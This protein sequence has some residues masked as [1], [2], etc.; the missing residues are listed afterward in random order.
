ME[1]DEN[2]IPFSYWSIRRSP[3]PSSVIELPRYA[4]SRPSSSSTQMTYTTSLSRS[5]FVKPGISFRSAIVNFLRPSVALVSSL[6]DLERYFIASLILIW[7]PLSSASLP[8][9]LT[10]NIERASLSVPHACCIQTSIVWSRLSKHWKRKAWCLATGRPYRARSSCSLIGCPASMILNDFGSWM[11]TFRSW[12]VDGLVLRCS[13]CNSR[14]FSPLPPVLFFSIFF[15]ST[16]SASSSSDRTSSNVS[17]SSIP[18]SSTSESRSA[19]SSS[20]SPITSSFSNAS[21]SVAVSRE[22][23][24]FLDGLLGVS[25]GEEAA[26]RF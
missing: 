10:V 19:K 12:N 5:S 21:S 25:S 18:K 1:N 4:S 15:G 7:S 3:D 16:T 2:R 17:S 14:N 22:D 6:I 26:L 9:F 24:A 13:A 11:Y 8:R 20:D 23:F